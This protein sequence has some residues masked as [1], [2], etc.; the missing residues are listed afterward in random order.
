M[1]NQASQN[2]IPIKEVRDGIVVLKDG[3]LRAIIMVSSLNFDLKS[4]D[5][6]NALVSQFQ[7]LLNSLEFSIQFFIQSRPLNIEP[8][9]KLLEQRLKDIPEE[10]LQVQTKE[11]IEFIRWFTE[12][13][14]IMRKSF[15]VVVP[16]GSVAAQTKGGGFV[17]KLFSNKKQQAAA[18]FQRFEEA[19]S[20]L[21]QRVSVVQQGLSGIGVRGVQLGTQE[22]IEV[23]YKIFNPGDEN[24]N[25]NL[26]QD[27][28]A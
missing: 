4:D 28:K 24:R 7:N 1:S 10:L 18:D 21:E 11:Y 2:F 27:K 22:V 14:S 9:I 8:Y 23:Y 20:Q 25:I 6:Q 16:Y 12:Q 3:G 19:R 15:F 5:E 26:E 13:S 17:S